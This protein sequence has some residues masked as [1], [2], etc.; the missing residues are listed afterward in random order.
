MSPSQALEAI[1]TLLSKLPPGTTQEL[2]NV[3][4]GVFLND[5][6]KASRALMRALLVRAGKLSFQQTAE[7]AKKQSAKVKRRG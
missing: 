7:Q 4:E 2:Y 5:G 1:N 6:N 3:V